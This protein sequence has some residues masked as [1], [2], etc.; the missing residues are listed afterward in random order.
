MDQGFKSAS[1]VAEQISQAVRA[2]KRQILVLASCDFSH[3]LSPEDGMEKDQ[4]VLD[5][6]LSRDTEEVERAVRKLHASICG[7]GPIMVL[8]EYARSL[9]AEYNVEV[10]ARGHSGEVI[11]SREVVDYISIMMYQ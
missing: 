5:H 6:I 2:T 10:L 3:F 9:Y 1:L 11:P 8:M 7:Y 4:H